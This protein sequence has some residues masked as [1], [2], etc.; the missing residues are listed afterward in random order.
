[1]N[2]RTSSGKI[3]LRRRSI[4]VCHPALLLSVHVLTGIA[5]WIIGIIVTLGV[6]YITIKHDK[7]VDVCWFSV[8]PLGGYS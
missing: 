7:I 5:W 8:V 3:H 2:T 6:A 4:S 1:M